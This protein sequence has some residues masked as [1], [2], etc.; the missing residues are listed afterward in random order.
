MLCSTQHTFT[1]SSTSDM[2][3]TSIGSLKMRKRFFSI[4]KTRSIVLRTDSHL[5]PDAQL[6]L[7]GYFI[8]HIVSFHL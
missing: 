5:S 1:K 3:L 2:S 7:V 6:T 4:P 8:T